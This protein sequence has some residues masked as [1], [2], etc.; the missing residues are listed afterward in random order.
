MITFK[1]LTMKR[2]K[3]KCDKDTKVI[4]ISIIVGIIIGAFDT[5]LMNY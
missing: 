5:V 4:L 3:W 1:K 2:N